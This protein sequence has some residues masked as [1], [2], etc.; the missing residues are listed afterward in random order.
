[1]LRQPTALNQ[2]RQF[3]KIFPGLFLNMINLS[4]N[5]LLEVSQEILLYKMQAVI[6]L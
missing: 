3:V 1:M 2:R 5:G 4:L 6:F